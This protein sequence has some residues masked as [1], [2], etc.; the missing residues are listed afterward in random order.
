MNKGNMG[1]RISLL[2]LLLAVG[3]PIASS[4][5]DTNS[6]YYGGND[7]W[8]TGVR[9][10][11]NHYPTITNESVLITN[12][13]SK[14]VTIDSFIPLFE[15]D[16]LTISNLTVGGTGGASNTLSLN[17]MNSG[18]PVPLHVLNGFAI[19]NSGVL[20]VTNSMLRVDG[21]LGGNFNVD[22]TVQMLQQAD[23]QVNEAVFSSNAVV[24]FALGTTSSVIV[25]SNNLTIAGSINVVDGGGLTT[26]NYTLFTYGGTL[27]DNGLVV[28][29]IP[30][31]FVGEIDTTTAGQVNLVVSLA[32]PPPS[33]TFRITSI[34][35][36][37]NDIVI[38]WL[39][40]G[41]G[42]SNI[43]QVSTGDAN[44]SYTTNFVDLSP[45]MFITGSTTNYTDS[46]GATNSPS[47]FYRIR[48]TGTQTI[49]G[50]SDHDGLPDSWEIQYFGNLD[51]T[52]IGDFDGDG[53]NN[54][55]E[56]LAGTDPTN[57]ASF[58]H[59]TAIAR[60]NTNDVRVT[61]MMGAG[62]TNA[63]QRT[64]GDAGS[65]STNNFIDI[66]T[67]TNTVGSVTNYLDVG[68]ATNIPSQFYRVRVVP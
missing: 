56:Y 17:D 33:S 40:T 22:G 62:R 68:G 12:T 24:Q 6:W 47:R 37:G 23:V 21:I 28:G 55:Q 26:T 14:T 61:W 31:N 15:Q 52:G 46:N 16:A 53:F 30:T 49:G 57:P 59:I 60:E 32:P 41:T 63:L 5:A 43:V 19:T 50:D 44:G 9:W 8:D 67:V 4:Q 35:Q 34:V 36:Q 48:S 51:Q 7:L 10:S 3:F 65:Y 38:A 54:L 20:L 39:T 66:F 27:I 58:I 45:P 1:T 42:T 11:L 64:S 29:T 25:V 13:A 2:I 18:G